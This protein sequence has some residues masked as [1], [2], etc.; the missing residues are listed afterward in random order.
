ML[1]K[2]YDFL[3]VLLILVAVAI[4]GYVYLHRESFFPSKISQTSTTQL[5]SSLV[6]V[7]VKV[8]DKWLSY[9]DPLR[10]N[11]LNAL[12]GSNLI[13]FGASLNYPSQIEV[14]EDYIVVS[15]PTSGN[16]VVL[17]DTNGDN[18][19]DEKKVFASSLDGPYGISYYNKDLYVA[20]QSKVLKYPNFIAQLN[21]GTNDS[22]VLLSN[23]P[24]IGLNKYKSILA[25]VDGRILISIGSSCNDCIEQDKRRGSIISY[26]LGGDDEKI[27]ATGL[28]NVFSM[29]LNRG[30]ILAVEDNLDLIDQDASE[31]I[32]QILPGKSYGWPQIYND[33]SANPKYGDFSVAGYKEPLILFSKNSDTRGLTPEDSKLGV[34][35]GAI[36]CFSGSSSFDSNS[37][38]V[39]LVDFSTGE[40]T[41][42]VSF[43]N[44]KT[45]FVG[46]PYDIKKYKNGWLITDIDNGFVYYLDF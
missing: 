40:L 27:Y 4:F 45:D 2:I 13:L 32:N 37:K 14:V 30:E 26:G 41:D 39:S 19:A 5:Y 42:I 7:Q 43:W 46:T 12:E 31:E 10:N 44:T 29:S 22:E 24:Y 33:S 28:K 15:E 35:N 9:A 18:S 38:K 36:I 1:A 17:K 34:L 3:T 8:S 16:L 20:T 6:P 25:G 21:S 11:K 23:L